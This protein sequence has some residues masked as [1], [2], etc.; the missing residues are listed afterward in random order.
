MLVTSVGML[1]TWMQSL[2]RL[3]LESSPWPLPEPRDDQGTEDG[4]PL[5]TGLYWY[6]MGDVY[7]KENGEGCPKHFDPSRPSV[8]Y[9]HG[10][11]PHTVARSVPI[12]PLHQPT[13]HRTPDSRMS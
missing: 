13:Q 3:L 12:S 9:V 7:E 6:G 4:P 8:I 10:F 2:L 11:Q 1:N 5:E